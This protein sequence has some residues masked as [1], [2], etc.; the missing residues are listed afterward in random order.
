MKEQIIAEIGWNHMGDMELAKQMIIAA[1]SSGADYAKFQTW[2]VSR[3]TKG[4]WDFDGRREIYEKAELSEEKHIYLIDIC[5]EFNIKFLSSAFS[6]EDAKLL[7]NLNCKEI[8]IP[9]FEC[10][11]FPLI[12]YCLENFNRVIISTGTANEEEI[13]ELSKKVD[14]DKSTI[15]HCVS[16]YPC[17]PRN[18]NL[19]RINALKKY[20]KHVG[21]S[22]HTQGL[23]VSCISLEYDIE[24]I[25]KHFT[26]NNELP[27]R[28]NKF[29]L[30]PDDLMKL[31][32]FKNDRIDAKKFLGINYQNIE[33]DSR[34]NYRRRFDKE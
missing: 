13:I 14:Q 21:F 33:Q 25:E 6:I 19:P 30:L 27:G 15:M 23:N 31:V 5:K 10:T 18:S 11:N 29:A 28:D 24:F 22:D 32:K 8:K 34:E 12:S 1:S 3:L 7:K 4:S 26:I 17:E 9:S 2:K 16:S 20:F